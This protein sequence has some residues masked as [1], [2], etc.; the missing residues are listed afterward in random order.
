MWIG[1]CIDVY[2]DVQ[3]E[4]RKTLY[5]EIKGHKETAM[6]AQYIREKGYR[7]GRQREV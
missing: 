1:F 3:E 6:L 4:K 2:A 7:Q 5:Q